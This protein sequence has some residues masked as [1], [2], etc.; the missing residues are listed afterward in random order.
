M[1]TYHII[2]IG[3]QMNKSDSERM[4]S[5]LE[6]QGYKKTDKKYQSDLVVVNTCGIRQMAEDRIYGLIPAIKKANKKTKII[7]TGCL[8]NRKDVKNRLKKYVDVWKPINEI[9]NSKCPN[10]Y[11]KIEPNYESKFSAYVPIGNGCNNFCS[12]CVVPYARGREVCRPAKEILTE[13]KKL[14]KNDYKEIVLIAQ[15]VNSYKSGEIDFADL[16]K[17]VDEI[18]GDFWVRFITS[19]PKDMSDKLIKVIAGSKKVCRHIHLPV[20]AGD[21]KILALMNRKYTVAHYKSLIKKI[22]KAMPDSSITTDII[23]GFPSETK[24]QSHNT[25]KLMKEAKFDLAYVVRYSPRPGTASFKLT[26]NVSL[27]EKKVRE[28]KLTR[29]LS[30]TALANNKKYLGKNVKLLVEGKGKSGEWFGKTATEKNVKFI[31]K[32]DEDSLIGKFVNVKIIKAKDFGLEGE[33][34]N[35]EKS[36]K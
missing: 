30:S 24:K 27:R 25:A 34:I 13:V 15:N 29:I 19:H 4:A 33:M 14:V 8:V 26:D 22:R 35:Y 28:N 21:D 32:N 18:K 20:Q 3:C 31:A 1:K 16:L 6:Q 12:Y 9:T 5:L 17:M 36:G 23:V 2:T 7:L 10:D 11:L